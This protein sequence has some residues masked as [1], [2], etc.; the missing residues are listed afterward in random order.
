MDSVL[1]GRLYRDALKQAGAGLRDPQ[2]LPSARVLATMHKDFDD[3][4]VRFTRAQS[5]QT[6][7]AMLAAPWSP[8]Q[9]ARFET[10]AAESVAGQL[11]IEAADTMPFEV[12]RQAYLSPQRLGI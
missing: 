5:T 6:R 1:G 7:N 11:R 10:M 2:S 3:S 12:Y 8:D 9:Q 4:F